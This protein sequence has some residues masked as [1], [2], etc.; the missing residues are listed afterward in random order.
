MRNPFILSKRNENIPAEKCNKEVLF[1]RKD[2][3]NK[4]SDQSADFC[5][6]RSFLCIINYCNSSLKQF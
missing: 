2:Y 3:W 1:M 5:F 4:L 6:M